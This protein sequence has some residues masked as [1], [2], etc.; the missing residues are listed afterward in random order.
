MQ[1]LKVKNTDMTVKELQEGGI[2]AQNFLL[3]N[4]DE[5]QDSIKAFVRY[6]LIDSVDKLDS[7][8]DDVGTEIKDVKL[9]EHVDIPLKKAYSDEF[10]F[11]LNIKH[12]RKSGG[13]VFHGGESDVEGF[14]PSTYFISV[15]FELKLSNSSF[16]ITALNAR[17]LFEISSRG[18]YFCRFDVQD[19]VDDLIFSINSTLCPIKDLSI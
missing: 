11:E 6:H 4:K 2:R 8:R 12:V 10:K 18:S 1:E 17:T 14:S 15:W 13:L 3:A 5:L 16:E 19:F 7:P 9:V